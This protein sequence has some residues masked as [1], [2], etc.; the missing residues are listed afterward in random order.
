MQEN[1]ETVV[2]TEEPTRQ[3]DVKRNKV[4]FKTID[5]SLK[6]VTSILLK[7]FTVL[8]IAVTAI[9]VLTE[10]LDNRYSIQQFHMPAEFEVNGFTGEVV[11]NRI[12]DALVE[13]MTTERFSEEAALYSNAFSQR[14]IS[15][16]VVGAGIPIRSTIDVIGN[17][18]G[19]HRKKL[20]IGNLVIDG[21]TAILTVKVQDNKPLK[22]IIPFDGSYDKVVGTVT[23]KAAESILMYSSPYVLARHYLFRDPDGNRSLSKFLFDQ[24]ITNKKVEPL[25]Y[26]SLAGALVT[27]H[28]AAAA[29][30]VLREGLMKS[31]DD[32]NLNAALGTM[33]Q[34][35]S[36]GVECL[37]Q[38][39]KVISMFTHSTT[40]L[41]KTLAYNNLALAYR[42]NNKID[43]ALYFFNAALKIDQDA[44]VVY[45]NLA[46]TQ[47][48]NRNDTT[49]FLK[50]LEIALKKGMR[51]RFVNAY[52]LQGMIQD[53]R[54]KEL[55]KD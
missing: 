22:Y 48:L 49:E 47:L 46:R 17:A 25:A 13:I 23:S 21:D 39:K 24:A 31:P 38:Q 16:D 8:L 12:S 10:L 30:K 45:L 34:E 3:V 32:I 5:R 6:L 1:V 28:K 55:L 14:D 53:P 4:N 27:E 52:D 50:N 42:I 43:S 44:G 9:F 29:E 51:D 2:Q 19:I 41:R 37:I 35:Q 40:K 26:F 33:L 54:V 20:V 18:L 15:V 36:K 7:T 11:A